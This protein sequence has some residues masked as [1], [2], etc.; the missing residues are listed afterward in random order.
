M[1]GG[2]THQLSFNT[3][4]GKVIAMKTKSRH[5]GKWSAKGR[6]NGSCRRKP[7]LT[8]LVI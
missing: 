4:L 8:N 1:A 7:Q 3:P 6:V 5:A 2:I